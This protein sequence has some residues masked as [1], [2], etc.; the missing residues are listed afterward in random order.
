MS[1]VLVSI[2]GLRGVCGAICNVSCMTRLF[3]RVLREACHTCMCVCRWG[4]V[5]A[6]GWDGA[7]DL[8]VL[9]FQ[10]QM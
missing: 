1:G 7:V 9:V 6:C 4:C 10:Q 5:H 8:V 3:G 2:R